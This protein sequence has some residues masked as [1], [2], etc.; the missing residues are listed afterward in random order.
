MKQTRVTKPKDIIRHWHIIDLKGEILGR[1]ASEIAQILI[2]KSKAYYSPNLDCGDYVVAINAKEIKLTG[3]KAANKLY[4]HHTGYPGGFR[5][6]TFD[7]LMA[8]DP[9]IAIKKAVSGMLP[10]NKLRSNRLK[11]LKIFTNDKHTY[12]DKFSSQKET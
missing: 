9:R 5:E 10:K 4:R 12:K 2:G 7:Q 1:S 6:I 8:K 3:K 11:R